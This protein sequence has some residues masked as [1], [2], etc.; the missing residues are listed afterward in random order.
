VRKLDALPLYPYKYNQILLNRLFGAGFQHWQNDG[1][2]IIPNGVRYNGGSWGMYV[3]QHLDKQDWNTE[4]QFK[5]EFDVS[6]GATY[7]YLMFF[8]EDEGDYPV[9]V[10]LVGLSGHQVVTFGLGETYGD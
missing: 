5:F 4:G 9:F 7:S 10:E 3:Q 6:G 8:D 2:T 1:G